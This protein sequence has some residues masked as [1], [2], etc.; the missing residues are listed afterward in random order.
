VSKNFG[1]NVSGYLDPT[2]RN[3][4]TTVFQAG[5]AVLDKELNLVQDA[6][7]PPDFPVSGW[8]ALDFTATSSSTS[9]FVQSSTANQLHL[10]GSALA[11][12]QGRTL[13][14]SSTNDATDNILD[15]GAGPSGA[16][17]KRTDLVILEV[18]RML[19]SASPS[20]V[21][22][23]G[24]GRIWFLGNVKIPSGSDLTLN[25]VDDILDTNVASET[26]KRVQIQYRLRVIKG[27]D[28][29]AHPYGIDDPTVFANTVPTNAATPDGTA[30]TFAYVNQSS[31]GDPGL[32][33]AGDGNPSNALGTVDG[34]MYAI[35]LCAVFRRNTTAFSR[36]TNHNG[37]VASPGPSDRPDGLFQDI[38]VPRDFV[39]LRHGVA[40]GGWN[41]AE[42][43][44]K[45]FNLLLDNQTQTEWMTTPNGG[46]Y[47]GHTVFWGDE[48]GISTGNGGDGTTTGD[49]PGATFIGQFDST[50]RTISDRSIYEVM[51][52]S[53][54]APGGGWASDATITIDPSTLAIYPFSAINWASF[55]PTGV[56][57]LDVLAMNFIATSSPT[58]SVHQGLQYVQNITGIN[59]SPVA[60]IVITLGTI[61]GAILTQTLYVDILVAYPPGVGLTMT[62]TGTYSGT[63]SVNNP[64]A[65]S[66]SSPI[67]FSAMAG[68][69]AIDFPHREAL[70]QYQTSQLSLT[71]TA[72][73]SGSHVIFLPERATSITN[74]QKNGVGITGSVTLDGTGRFFTFNNGADFPAAGDAISFNYVAIRPI[75]QC[76]VQMTLYYD[77]RAPQTARSSLV[78][79]TITLTPRLI[80]NAVYEITTGSGSQDEGYP[81]P[82]AYAQM[83]GVY[84]TSASSF[85]GE[86]EL[87][88]S[89]EIDFPGFTIASGFAQLGSFIP[90]VTAPEAMTFNRANGD[91]DIEGRTFF[92]SVPGGGYIPNAFGVSMVNAKRHRNVLPVLAEIASDG[93]LGAS[94]QLVLVLLLRDAVFD[95]TNGVF[96]V[97]DLTQNRTSAAV[98]RIKGHPLIR[99]F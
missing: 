84:P 90:F 17:A 37:G 15:L 19:I 35:P 11:I 25:F 33:L 53:I 2:G 70:I 97:N 63:F 95:D 44:Q 23:S 3:F 55:A 28:L 81:F 88:A 67:S 49:T 4:E 87:A 39:D 29:F 16:G 76:G 5:K 51:T 68:S 52:V 46:G 6:E 10:R 80:G 59:Q 83:G 72:D 41:Y 38:I 93:L 45:S 34:F 98:F 94:G 22:K 74:V 75:P 79:S 8:V 64:S 65:L 48:I 92:K 58:A 36:N 14:I 99:R 66:A 20:T 77:A 69:N 43:L 73:T 13:S 42:I 86:H 60:S 47:N 7:H 71:I 32:W 56:Q 31:N 1:P 78:G 96:F 27:V 21:G 82:S 85:A 40:P 91:I 24:S 54:P 61:P 50:R 12:V 30:S 26:T 89:G 57:F 18:W 62:P 9:I